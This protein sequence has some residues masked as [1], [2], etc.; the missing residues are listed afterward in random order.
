MGN[1]VRKGYYIDE[2][3][4]DVAFGFYNRGY[5]AKAENYRY[6]KEY[7]VGAKQRKW[8]LRTQKGWEAWILLR[9]KLFGKRISFDMVQRCNG[10]HYGDFC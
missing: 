10:E 5:T 1:I 4:N 7:Y 9:A 8:A 6:Y 2:V 3:E